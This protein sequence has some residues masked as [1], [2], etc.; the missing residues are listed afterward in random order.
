[1]THLAKDAITKPTNTEEKM[2]FQGSKQQPPALK[3]HKEPE[4]KLKIKPDLIFGRLVE[5]QELASYE[6]QV[7]QQ[8]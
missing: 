8:I 2:S 1:L 7:A 3:K 6:Q 5:G 4:Y